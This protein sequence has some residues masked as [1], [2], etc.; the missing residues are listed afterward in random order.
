MSFSK[1]DSGIT[2]SSCWSLPYHVRVVWVS[3]LAKKDEN[4]FV[5]VAYSRMPAIANVTPEEFDE[6]IRIL[7]SPDKESRTKDHDG[8]RLERFEGGWLVLNHEKYRLHSEIVRDQSRERVRRFREKNRNVTPGN[9]TC[10]LPSV[11]VSSLS[12]GSKT[13]EEDKK[14]IP[15]WRSDFDIYSKMVVD[16]AIGLLNDRAEI[17]KQKE[18]HPGVDIKKSIEKAVHNFWGQAA[19]WKYKKKSKSKDIDMRATLINAIALNKVYLPK[20]YGSD[21]PVQQ[22]AYH[23]EVS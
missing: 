2:D 13:T 12:S 23:R 9:V 20:E 3:F 7:E 1:L 11:S 4:G 17:D 18:F 19:G 5:N 8:R 14:D 10:A 22:F 21:R 16:S 6:A 15:S